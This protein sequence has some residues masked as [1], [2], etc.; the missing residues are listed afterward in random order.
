MRFDL[1]DEYGTLVPFG[2]GLSKGNRVVQHSGCAGDVAERN[3]EKADSSA[4]L[5]WEKVI[6]RFLRLVRRGN[7]FIH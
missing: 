2:L 7:Y 4:A 6:M 1:L 3:V 5:A